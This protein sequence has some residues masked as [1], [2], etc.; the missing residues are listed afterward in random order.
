MSGVNFI[1]SAF[2]AVLPG[3]VLPN[4]KGGSTVLGIVTSCSGVA[5]IVGSLVVSVLPEP[6]NRVKII[7][8]TMLF[9]LGTEN[10]LLAFSREP[11]LWCVG[12]IIGWVLVPV[13]SA[14]LDVILRT[15]I[16]VELQ[17]RVYACRNTFQFF[18]I[19]I[20]LFIGGFMVDNV[21]EPFMRVHGDLSILKMLFGTGKGSG[22]ALMML[23]LGVS[24]SLICIITGKKLKKYE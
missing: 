14:N 24:G 21:C 11:F 1:A 3:Y 19:P 8:W 4:P 22:A 5:M 23:I 12:Q 10:F 6:K 17:G 13:M 16:P 18:T 7:Y 9:S 20:G 15:S 2:D